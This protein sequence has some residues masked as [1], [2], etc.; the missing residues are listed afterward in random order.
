MNARG[1]YA[2]NGT[3]DTRAL[4]RKRE[5]HKGTSGDWANGA[6][7][8]TSAGS[9]SWEGSEGDLLKRSGGESIFQRLQDVLTFFRRRMEL[10]YYKELCCFS[11]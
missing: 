11:W 3:Y 4:A 8:T 2:L 7:K 10:R 9:G 6:T 1:G 5:E